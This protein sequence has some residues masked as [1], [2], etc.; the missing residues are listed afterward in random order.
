MLKSVSNITKKKT[1][2]V[3]DQVNLFNQYYLTNLDSSV[4]HNTHNTITAHNC[5]YMLTLKFLLGQ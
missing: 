3:A 1:K 5:T 2:Y 4:Q